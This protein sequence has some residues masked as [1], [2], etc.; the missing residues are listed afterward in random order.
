MCPWHHDP[1]PP[2]PADYWGNVVEDPGVE[3]ARAMT[4]TRRRR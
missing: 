1:F 2:A 4:G 3:L